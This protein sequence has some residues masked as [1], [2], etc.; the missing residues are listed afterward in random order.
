MNRKDW[1]FIIGKV[2]RWNTEESEKRFSALLPRRSRLCLIFVS[3]FFVIAQ[4]RWTSRLLAVLLCKFDRFSFCP[5]RS[6]IHTCIFGK[7]AIDF[8]ISWLNQFLKSYLFL[9]GTKRR[10][11]TENERDKL[12]A[13]TNPSCDFNNRTFT[14]FFSFS[15]FG[16]ARTSDLAAFGTR[17]R[18]H[19]L[20][21]CLLWKKN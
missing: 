2:V 14:R 16:D 19:K 17:L 3:G 6:H 15:P 11:E 18:R 21:L 10:N 9:L 5:D 7:L 1:A 13:L 12:C 20:E 4:M 8:I